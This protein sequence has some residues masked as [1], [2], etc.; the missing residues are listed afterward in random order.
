[1]LEYQDSKII[2][3][4]YKQ[5][6]LIFIMKETPSNE[7]LEALRLTTIETDE[8]F[9][10]FLEGFDG[11]LRPFKYVERLLMQR[12]KTSF[13]YQLKIVEMPN[14]KLNT[15]EKDLIMRVKKHLKSTTSTHF[16]VLDFID[17]DAINPLEV[18]LF[19][20]LMEKR[21]FIPI[22]EDTIASLE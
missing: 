12:L 17:K 14:I 16:T 22:I 6:R 11:D 8:K 5:F 7:F 21:I 10:R 2:M 18:K 4:E 1:K 15:L 9:G 3:S 19:I 20:D 13:L